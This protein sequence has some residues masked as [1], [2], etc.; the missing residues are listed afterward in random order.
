M[1]SKLLKLDDK[2]VF[3]EENERFKLG[4]NDKHNVL[5]HTKRISNKPKKKKRSDK[6]LLMRVGTKPTTQFIIEVATLI[7]LY[8]N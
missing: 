8:H 3:P 2:N 4:S 5:V 6:S 7:L 1:S